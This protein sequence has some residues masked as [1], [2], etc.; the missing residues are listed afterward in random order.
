MLKAEHMDESTTIYNSIR[1]P[2]KY[3][4][5]ETDLFK[6]IGGDYETQCLL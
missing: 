5:V 1:K 2:H 6:R 3:V 4:V